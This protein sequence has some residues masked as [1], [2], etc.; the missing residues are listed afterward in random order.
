LLIQ[1]SDYI[2]QKGT[3]PLIES[4]SGFGN[5]VLLILLK[6]LGVKKV[7]CVGL[8]YDFCVGSTAIDAFSNGFEVVVVKNL[9]RA[10]FEET[11]KEMECKFVELGVQVENI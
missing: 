1:P 11:T 3:D 4:F 5:P 7:Y 2:I 8:A 9:S 6:S 10:A